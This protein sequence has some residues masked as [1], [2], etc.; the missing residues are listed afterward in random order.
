MIIKNRW[1]KV[2]WF[3]KTYLVFKSPAT[4][5]QSFPTT[6]QTLLALHKNKVF[7]DVKSEQPVLG[8]LDT[9]Q[10]ER[11]GL[12]C[13]RWQFRQEDNDATTRLDGRPR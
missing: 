2:V 9:I 12:S 1:S 4:I 10:F 6:H 3:W 13:G 11:P 8:S 7:A 5:V